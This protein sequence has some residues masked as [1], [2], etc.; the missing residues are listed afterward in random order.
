MHFNPLRMIENEVSN[1][2]S[3]TEGKVVMEVCGTTSPALRWSTDYHVSTIFQPFL[4]VQFNL[5][6]W[7]GGGGGA[8]GNFFPPKYLLCPH[9]WWYSK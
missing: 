4:P 3:V 1:L 2:L 5:L 9:E 8:R 6:L 7:G